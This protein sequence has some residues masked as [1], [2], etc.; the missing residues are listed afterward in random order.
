MD[1]GA[2]SDGR[3]SD[4]TVDVQMELGGGIKAGFIENCPL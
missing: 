4:L 3:T 1:G 2:P